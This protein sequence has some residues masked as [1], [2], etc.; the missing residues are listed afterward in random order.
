MK[1]KLL[2]GLL[3][4]AVMTVPVQAAQKVP[5]QVDGQL[6]SL[7]GQLERGVTHVSLR[8]LLDAMGGWEV[9]WDAAGRQAV[10]RS[11]S[12]SLSADP[13]ADTVTID[14]RVHSGSVY[15]SGGRTY[16][17][18]RTV[19]EACGSRVIW[20]GY[21]GGAAVT[22]E[23]AAH[24]AEDLYWLARIISAE[25]RGESL[26]GQ[27]AVGN[28]VLNRVASPEFPNTIRGVIF[29]QVDG[30]QFEPVANGTVYHTPTAQAEAAARRVLAG[31]NVIGRCLYFYAP[32]LSQGLW[33]NANRTYVRTIGCHRFYL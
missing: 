28:V 25:S 12:R 8:S 19:A 21:L 9:T 11:G 26:E 2:C 16:V 23:H 17:P 1:R 3:A 4:A 29:D 24:A 22:T 27:I 30:V 10:A 18:L 20:D 32:A 31:E 13:G 7:S 14:G 5:V 15:L 6:L 33:I